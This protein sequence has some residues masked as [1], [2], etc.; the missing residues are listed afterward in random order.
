M[1]Y[2][3]RLGKQATSKPILKRLAQHPLQENIDAVQHTTETE[4][5]KTAPKDKLKAEQGESTEESINEIG[6]MDFVNGHKFGYAYLIDD[7]PRSA[8]PTRVMLR[9]VRNGVNVETLKVDRAV[10]AGIEAYKD[11]F[12]VL[13]RA[14]SPSEYRSLVIPSMNDRY[15]RRFIKALE[16][17]IGGGVVIPLDIY[18]TLPKVQSCINYRRFKPVIVNLDIDIAKEKL[19]EM[20]FTEEQA[21]KL[22]KLYIFMPEIVPHL[23]SFNRNELLQ[24]LIKILGPED[25]EDAIQLLEAIEAVVYGVK[26]YRYVNKMLMISL[27][28]LDDVRR[29]RRETGSQKN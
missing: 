1:E 5:F 4:K 19:L 12:L 24:Q 2:K 28:M 22:A 6:F 15:V 26:D 14:R 18:L 8:L 11:T 29:K 16:L 20:R 3:K 27:G 23:Q 25:P 9:W 17:G 7:I 13:T 10:K 21:G